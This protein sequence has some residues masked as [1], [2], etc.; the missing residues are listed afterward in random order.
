V[1]PDPALSPSN[2]SHYSRGLRWSFLSLVLQ[3]TVLDLILF[4]YL[5]FGTAVLVL[6]QF[7]LLLA[8]IHNDRAV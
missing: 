7:T 6:I 8:V 3:L 5:Q 1:Q 2:N 4:Y